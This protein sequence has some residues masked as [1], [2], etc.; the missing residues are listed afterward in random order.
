MVR[1]T[2]ERPPEGERDLAMGSFMNAWS[3]VEMSLR[4]LLQQLTNTSETVSYMLAA[5]ISDTGRMADLLV[6]LGALNLPPEDQKEL[7]AIRDYI[8]IQ[9]RYRNSIVHGFWALRPNATRRPLDG[10]IHKSEWVRVYYLIDRTKQG[11]AVVQ[12]DEKGHEKYVFNVPRL[13][14]RAAKS[15][16]FSDRIDALAVKIYSR[17]KPSRRQPSIVVNRPTSGRK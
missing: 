8:L 12:K 1:E 9:A 2:A 16:R 5:A 3:R 10:V 14:E 15:L 7:V 11:Q 4:L 17:T 6:A 13:A